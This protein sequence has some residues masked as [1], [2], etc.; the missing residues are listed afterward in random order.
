MRL[1]G[2]DLIV[3]LSPRDDQDRRQAH[4]LRRLDVEGRIRAHARLHEQA[5]I[6]RKAGAAARG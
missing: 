1:A 3:S 6:F 4:D 5:E 2:F